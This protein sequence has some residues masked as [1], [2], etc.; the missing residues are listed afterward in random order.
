VHFTHVAHLKQFHRTRQNTIHNFFMCRTRVY[1]H[2]ILYDFIHFYFSAGRSN[3]TRFRETLALFVNMDRR[4]RPWTSRKFPKIDVPVPVLVPGH[5]VLRT[6]GS[7][8]LTWFQGP[9]TRDQK[10]SKT[11]RCLVIQ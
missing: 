11:E 5:P 8:P 10:W 3:L 1:F 7:R 9:W 6:P 4:P 2:F